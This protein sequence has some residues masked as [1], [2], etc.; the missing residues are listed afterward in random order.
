MKFKSR[1]DRLE[2]MRPIAPWVPLPHLY[3]IVFEVSITAAFEIA[4]FENMDN[5][6]GSHDDRRLL[7]EPYW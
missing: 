3:F 4:P 5:L 1:L 6:N 7:Q 2:A